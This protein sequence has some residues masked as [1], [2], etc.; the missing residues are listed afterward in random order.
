MG[1]KEKERQEEE[2]MGEKRRQEK[3]KEDKAKERR[4]PRPVEGTDADSD[5]GTIKS[6]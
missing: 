6:S 4:L 3:G 5:R 1:K 2:K